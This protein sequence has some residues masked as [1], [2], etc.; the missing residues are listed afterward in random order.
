MPDAL[1][2][3]NAGSSSLKFALYE[4]GAGRHLA[5]TATGEIEGI[6]TAPHLVA[7][8]AAGKTPLERRWPAGERLSHEALFDALLGEIE[9]R[10]VGD[11]LCGVGHR[12]VH[13][14]A[15]FA[16]P[17]ILSDEV[18][19][20]LDALVPLAP[21]HQPHNLAAIRAIAAV[22]PA[23]P[24]IGCFDT[25][26]HHDMPPA[27][28][29]FGLPRSCEGEGIRRYGFHGLSYE[30]IAG[31][32]ARLAPELHRIVVA[33]LGN[34]ASLCAL[35]DGRSVDTTMSFTPLDGLVMGTRCGALDPGVIVYL[36][37]RGM[38]AEAIEELL[39]HRSGLL[40]V[41]GISSD[42]R[43]L[44]A[45]PAAAAREAIELFVFHCARQTAALAAS[46]GGLDAIVFTAGIGEHAPT[47]R[48]AIAERL[49]WLGVELDPT[50]NANGMMRI[51][52]PASRVAALV[53]PTD[54]QLMIARH[55]L[56]L[57][58]RPE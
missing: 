11:R 7:S 41:S 56:A 16:A 35:Q 9:Q 22:R 14:G 23:L 57:I 52:T 24:Q 4:I 28:R 39:Y 8:D 17:T 13:G 38:D 1:L 30:Y 2:A 15:E 46:L 49:A 19:R 5:R 3:L 43:A 29:R 51:G 42:M 53:V 40:G 31:E 10:L 37:R 12:I 20:R 26:F 18:L 44:L 47:I 58:D 33:H 36:M 54:E 50:A 6:G 27:A 45:S 21:L 48:A 34:G 32:L 55:T 25:A